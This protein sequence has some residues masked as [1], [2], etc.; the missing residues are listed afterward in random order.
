[1]L[2][3]TGNEEFVSNPAEF[4]DVTD[5]KARVAGVEEP[6]GKLA[7]VLYGRIKLMT[8]QCDHL[9]SQW[10]VNHGRRSGADKQNTS[11]R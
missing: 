5:P 10:S 7:I 8:S 1:V 6:M 4:P 3:K 9:C 2:Y 11:E